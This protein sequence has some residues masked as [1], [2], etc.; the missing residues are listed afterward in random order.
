MPTVQQR[1]KSLF[2]RAKEA[3]TLSKSVVPHHRIDEV[4]R[5]DLRRHS[6]L[7]DRALSHVP[8]LELGTDPQTGVTR[9]RD[10]EIAPDLWSDLFYSYYTSGD[11]IEVAPTEDIAPGHQLHQRIMA[12]LLKDPNFQATRVRTRGDDLSAGLAM[13][14]AQSVLEPELATKLNEHAERAGTMNALTEALQNAEN[15]LE[16]KREE[17]K[18]QLAQGGLSQAIRNEIRDLAQD[19]SNARHALADMIEQQDETTMYREVEGIVEQAAQE[20]QEVAETVGMMPGSVRGEL[21]RMAP[22]QAFAMATRWKDNPQLREVLQFVGRLERDFRYHRSHRVQGGREE[23]V[24]VELGNDVSLMLPTELLKLGH[25]SLRIQFMQQYAERTLL[26][27]ETVGESES[28]DGPMLTLLDRSG[29]MNKD[30]KMIGAAA[31]VLALLSVAKRENRAFA[32]IDFTTA[33]ETTH[34]FPKGKRVDPDAVTDIAATSGHGGTDITAPLR[35]AEEFLRTQPEFHTADI[36]LVTDG[37]DR[38]EEADE[39]I[40]ERLKA[41]GVRIHSFVVGRPETLY[42]NMASRITDGTTVSVADLLGPSEATKQ[43]VQAI[44]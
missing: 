7:F 4:V 39:Q 25:E 27:Y 22:D 33:V 13:A 36:V 29:S 18:E 9:T 37:A 35:R 10:Y 34:I 26:Q 2:S 28:G 42:T 43:I 1:I 12:N 38:W 23:I 31:T 11:H 5:D 20:A 16:Q 21:S 30:K 44:T 3:P 19:K 8:T 6:G 41:M 14:A 24:D 17:A 32:N 15:Q 40:C